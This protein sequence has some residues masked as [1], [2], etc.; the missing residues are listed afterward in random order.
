M[1]SR[2]KDVDLLVKDRAPSQWEPADSKQLL[3]LFNSGNTADVVFEHIRSM[4]E[5]LATI[6]TSVAGHGVAFSDGSSIL[7]ERWDDDGF[8]RCMDL[9]IVG[10]SA[11]DIFPDDDVRITHRI[12]SGFRYRLT[13]AHHNHS[14]EFYK[15]PISL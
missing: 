14:I 4:S 12:I 15:Q 13:M 10:D 5:E 6:P 11:F 1:H 7:L 8:S 3:C 2:N 9:K